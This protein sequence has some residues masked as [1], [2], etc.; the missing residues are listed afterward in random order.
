MPMSCAR[1]TKPFGDRQGDQGISDERSNRAGHGGD[2]APT[3]NGSPAEA[4][5]LITVHR[6]DG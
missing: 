5:L 6:G 4:E 2:A 1:A 3:R